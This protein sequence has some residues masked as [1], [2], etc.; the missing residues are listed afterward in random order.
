MTGTL[1]HGM[2]TPQYAP[3]DSYRGTDQRSDVYSLGGPF[4]PGD[5]RRE[6]N[7]AL[8]RVAGT[9]AGPA[10]QAEEGFDTV[11]HAIIKALDLKPENRFQTAASFG[12]P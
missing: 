3:P 10:A 6:T 1:L 2:G 8:D 7:A 4:V 9:G 12:R 5:D 11:D